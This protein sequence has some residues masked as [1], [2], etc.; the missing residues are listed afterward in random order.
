[1]NQKNHFI[2]KFLILFL[3]FVAGLTIIGLYGDKVEKDIVLLQRNNTA[4]GRVA[5]VAVENT[6][7]LIDRGK[8]TILKFDVAPQENMTILDALI[9]VSDR[10]NIGL[11]T[12][13]YDTGTLVT[14][15]AGEK[16][17]DG[18]KYWIYYVNNQMA[19]SAVDQQIVRTGD[20]IEFRLEKSSF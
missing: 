9:N 15:L 2:G 8:G 3:F 16:S 12:K 13:K 19:A 10:Y 18:G 11:E 6:V 4:S 7:L 1:M 17:G 20:K 5:G 14:S